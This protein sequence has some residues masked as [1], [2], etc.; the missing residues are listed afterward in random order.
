MLVY[1]SYGVDWDIIYGVSSGITQIAR[2]SIQRDGENIVW[3]FPVNTTFKSTNTYGWP[4]VSLAVYGLDFLG[5]DVVR[6]YGSLLVPASPGR[7]AKRV[8]TYTPISASACVRFTNWIAGTL[9]EYCNIKFTAQS[10]GR[11]VT[12][13]QTEGTVRI[14][15]NVTTKEME[16]FG[17]VLQRKGIH[18]TS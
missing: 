10:D 16:N 18:F 17:F 14:I 4:R 7:Y 11:A 1:L 6:G 9:A 15:M 13:V 8:Q 12:R 2:R 5:R 3:N